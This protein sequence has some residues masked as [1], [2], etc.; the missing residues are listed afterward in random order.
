M[1]LG[2][3]LVEALGTTVFSVGGG[4]SSVLLP[5]G[6]RRLLV[7]GIPVPIFGYLGEGDTE[8]HEQALARLRGELS[9]WVPPGVRI[10]AQALGPGAVNGHASRVLEWLPRFRE[11][12]RE[13]RL[14]VLGF[15]LV[16]VFPV[17]APQARLWPLGPEWAVRLARELESR[18]SDLYRILDDTLCRTVDGAEGRIMP[19]H[20]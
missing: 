10:D 15:A 6:L 14:P 5:V 8:V 12:G 2:R 16:T 17:E 7:L 19:Y 13:M 18:V 3:S 1:R 20:E 4:V 11:R 9:G